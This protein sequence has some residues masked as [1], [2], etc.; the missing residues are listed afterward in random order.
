[1][2]TWN[3]NF[4]ASPADSDAWKYG[5]NKIRELKVA[6]SERLELEM[7]FKTGTQPLIKAGIASVCYSGNTTDINALANMSANALAWDTTLAVLKRYNGNAWVALTSDHANLANLTTGDPHT[8]YLKLD[9]ANQTISA[10]LTVSAN[11][12]IDGRD[13]SVDGAR[14]DSGHL[15]LLPANGIMANAANISLANANANP[16]QWVDLSLANYIDANAVGAVIL[17]QMYVA[18]SDNGNFTYMGAFRPKGGA[19]NYVVSANLR[20]TGRYNAYAPEMH[21]HTLAIPVRVD[22]NKYI[23]YLLFKLSD[24]SNC[25]GTLK[26][27]V[28]GSLL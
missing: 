13:L 16:N 25:V 4:E 26:I 14:L 2:T 3:A 1:M 12:T 19:G 18:P 22:A 23:Q 27:G 21:Y 24:D 9:K 8:Q 28:I 17:A 5:A 10:N 7:N 11:T 6:I 20:V 15:I